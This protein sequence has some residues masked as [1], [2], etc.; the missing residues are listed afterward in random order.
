MLAALAVADLFGKKNYIGYAFAGQSKGAIAVFMTLMATMLGASSTLGIASRAEESGLDALWWPLAAATGLGLQALFSA[1]AARDSGC[2]TIPGLARAKIGPMA[3][4]ISSWTIVLAWP[5]IVAAQFAASSS[6]AATAF[7]VEDGRLVVLPTAAVVV[8]YTIAGGQEAVVKTDLLQAGI[9]FAAFLA[10]F[11]FVFSHGGAWS[12]PAAAPDGAARAPLAVLFP[13]VAGA[14]FLG[15]DIASRIFIAKDGKSARR[16]VA[17]SSLAMLLL[18]VAIVFASLWARDSLPGAGNPLVRI[19]GRLPFLVSALFSVG[20]FSALV[21]SA[22]TCLV[23]V[24]TIIAE[25]VLKRR[26]VGCVR[27]CVLAVG[28]ASAFMAIS[29]GDVLSLLAKAYS[30]YTPGL[31][32]PLTAALLCKTPRKGL[33]YA[34]MA[35]GGAAGLAE[36]LFSIHPALP[37]AGLALSALFSLLAC[38]MGCV[39]SGKRP[40]GHLRQVARKTLPGTV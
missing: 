2:A 29:G 18:G 38:I 36:A 27:I 3:Q 22:D 4:K 28:A 16:A 24:S 8:F 13:S 30:I 9:L 1:R 21:S 33:L 23:N 12:L 6:I 39:R 14:Y 37:M 25:D 15:P 7:G 32:A 40:D 11:G 31:V 34:S 35:V 17:A 20:L 19:S 10:L 26:S 5:A